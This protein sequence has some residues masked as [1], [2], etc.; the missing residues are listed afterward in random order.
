MKLTPQQRRAVKNRNHT[1]L[2]ACPGSGKTRAIVAKLLRCADEVRDTPRRVACITYTNAAVEEIDERLR[3]YGA[4]G[5]EDYCEVSTIHSFCL[6]NVLRPFHWKLDAYKRGFSILPSDSEVYIQLAEETLTEQGLPKS[7]LDD[8]ELLNR[9]PD[10]KPIV[11]GQLTPAAALSFWG[12]LSAQGY[13]D[14]AN[15]VYLSFRLLVDHPSIGHAMACRFAW[16]L[17]DEFQDTSALQVEILKIIGAQQRTRFFLVGDPYQSIY[18]FAGARPA[19]MTEFAD[20]IGADSDFKL[21]DNFRSSRPIIAQA[22]RLLPRR[23]PMQAAGDEARRFMEIPEHVPCGSPFEGITDFF[24]PTVDALKIPYGRCAI[25]APSWFPLYRLGPLLRDYKVPIYGVGARPYKRHHLFGLL[26][27]PI[28]AHIDSPSPDK[29]P[30]I[31]KG[32]FLM[33]TQATGDTNYRVFS[34]ET[35]VIIYRLL[36]AAKRLR[37]RFEGGIDWMRIAAE[38]F[39]QILAA[40]DLLPKRCIGLFRQS[41]S[42]IEQDM[43]NRGVDIANLTLADLGLFANPTHNV[44]LLTIHQAKGR[45]FDAVSIIDLHE[46]RIPNWRNKTQGA[47]EESKRQMYVAMTRA[48]RILMYI[49]D[50]SNRTNTPSPFIGT[51]LG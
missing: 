30:A 2:V 37:A 19:L 50:T 12:K 36:S 20:H 33:V 23:P 44:K 10:G 17:V 22:E 8:F 42:D 35:R 41:V 27:E 25:L 29:I 3:A 40:A 26:A 43:T 24:L 46:G 39:E 32:L 15:V 4:S 7:A 28:C 6:N 13:I 11:A 38:E 5:D 45:E 1:L 21:W 49:T 9:A 51:V 34:Y 14:F 18:S 16:I 31:E 48:R 47:L